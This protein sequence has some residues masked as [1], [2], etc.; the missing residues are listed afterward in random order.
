VIQATLPVVLSCDKGLNTPRF[1]SLR[2]IMMAK[3]KKIEVWGAEDLGVDPGS[4]GA[5]AALLVEQSMSLPPSRPSGRMIEGAS[6]G[7]K[8][9]ELVRL[10]RE[11][12]KVL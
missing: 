7:E 1:A 9:N 8:V 4:V 3:R 2:G 12:A 11:E 5:V 6:V 10:L